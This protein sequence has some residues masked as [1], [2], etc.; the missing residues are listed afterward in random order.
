[1]AEAAAALAALAL[2]LN[3]VTLLGLA[4]LQLEVRRSDLTRW[5]SPASGG[6]SA[7]PSDLPK[8]PPPAGAGA[9]SRPWPFTDPRMSALDRRDGLDTRRDS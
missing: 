7:R 1:M 6:Y 4:R 2:L 8:P 5:Q 3:G 9:G